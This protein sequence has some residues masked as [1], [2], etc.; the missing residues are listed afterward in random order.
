MMMKHLLFL[1]LTSLFIAAP[2]LA[3][4]ESTCQV[5][6]P[7][8]QVVGNET[9]IEYLMGGVGWTSG[10]ADYLTARIGHQ[11]DPPV[12]FAHT[13]A[14]KYLKT[15]ADEA[16]A[17][18]FDF[19][20]QN[21]YVV[22]CVES[23][24][25]AVPLV[26]MVSAKQEFD[27]ELIKATQI[28]AVL[29]TLKNRT[30]IQ[31]LDD[32][33]GRKVGTNQITN[34]ATH[35][36]YGVL[37][38]HGI[39]HL[40]DPQQVVYF[41][42]SNSA[43]EALLEGKVDVA[44]G[45]TATLDYFMTDDG[46]SARS[47]VKI[48]SPRQTTI[49]TSDGEEKDF[50]FAHTSE[51]VPAYQF[52]AFPHVPT[53][54]QVKIQQEFMDLGDYAA[55]APSLIECREARGCFENN[56]A[57]LEDCFR[58]LPPG[59]IKNCDTTPQL[60]LDAY[61]AMNGRMVTFDKP[62]N[63]FRVRDIQEMTG[64]LNKENPAKPEC[65]RMSNIVDAVTCPPGH[66]ARSSLEIQQECNASGLECFDRDCICN[67]CVKA[68]EVDFFPVYE[69]DKED[70]RTT[71][72][73]SGNG[74][75]KFALCG[76]IHQEHRLSFRAIDNKKRSNATMSGVFLLEDETEEPF[77]FVKVEH[78]DGTYDFNVDLVASRMTAGQKTIKIRIDD[79]EIPES[80]FRIVVLKRDCVADTGDANQ[81]PDDYG[82]CVCKSGTVDLFNKCTPLAILV[83]CIVVPVLVIF[84]LA[85]WLYVRH[86]RAK[87]DSVWKVDPSEIHFDDPP[88]ILG[89]GT[90][91]LVVLAEFRGTRVACKRALPPTKEP[92]GRSSSLLGSTVD[93]G[94]EHRFRSS[95]VL[96]S[97]VDLE[98]GQF[99]SK[100]NGS[101]QF[102]DSNVSL[103]GPGKM[104]KGSGFESTSSATLKSNGV[105][106]RTVKAAKMKDEFVKEMRLL[107]KLRHPSIT[108]V[109]GA[110]LS[111]GT[112]P[113]MIMEYMHFG[114]LYDLLHNECIEL[115]GE[116]LLGMLQDVVSGIR[117][118]HSSDPLILHGDL[119][120][121]NILVDSKF[122]A[123][124]ADFGLSTR[125]SALSKDKVRGTPY[126]MAPELLRRETTNN[127]ETDIYAMGI[128]I[129]EVF[130]RQDPYA[131]EEYDQVL[132]QVADKKT[133]KR[134]HV[135]KNCP[136]EVTNLMKACLREDP[137]HRPT[138]TELD[139]SF[140]TLDAANMKTFD[141][142]SAQK[143]KTDSARTDILLEDIFP[144]HIAQALKEGRKVEPE[145]HEEVTIVFSDIVGYTDMSSSMPATKVSDLLDRLYNAFDSLCE[146]LDIFKVET[147]GDAYMTVTN[148]VKPQP[149]HA[150]LAA[151]F[152]IEAMRVAST[153]PIDVDN[154]SAGFVQLRMGFHSGP[155]VTHVVGTR[156]RRYSLIGDTVNTSS[157]M[158]SNS[159]PGRILCSESTHRLLSKDHS[160]FRV[161][162]RGVIAV[163]GKGEMRTFW[164][165]P[166]DG[167][168]LSER[169]E[170]PLRASKVTFKDHTS[171][172][173]TL[174]DHSSSSIDV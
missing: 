86:H 118:L 57:C 132:R 136:S 88:Q 158:E 93:V 103:A 32:I 167:T 116:V 96:G 47:K 169:P 22:S 114:S 13:S 161:L 4:N 113:M 23:E 79:E 143:R 128:V 43:L 83:P 111:S 97:P 102:R 84:L 172:T 85:V 56:T 94:S 168:E 3:Q 60:A 2:T 99:V 135:P 156:N 8:L 140:R 171:V 33:K 107:S 129:F 121:H 70:N 45:A 146:R 117:F 61:E 159:K 106:G 120:S 151:K 48:L 25:Q 6:K 142:A 38:K 72:S 154:P 139:I 68:F 19:I 34:L 41:K 9:T 173:S 10:L 91:G 75:S 150:S 95:S 20:F 5:P 130:S 155:V 42:N 125:K 115:E 54:V 1:P 174:K 31:T 149:D 80:P 90:F 52:A 65:V 144:P 170:Q 137:S 163:K 7:N 109:M 123:K 11:F 36:C 98:S 64:F 50:P 164:V 162:E 141:E 104:S 30:D 58:E 77:S 21:A 110:V 46:T 92:R 157:R 39:H 160:D 18:G 12:S 108:T 89:R 26:S 166:R 15:P 78:F 53:P 69:D 66:F 133:S 100:S 153:V 24:V 27:G 152:A 35:L 145:T 76:R 55:V 28:G 14:N 29:Y 71:A 134:P 165:E 148:L 131:G 105:F 112:E 119:K 127:K 62:R 87:A 44:C 147:I 37:L 67:P 122:K 49:V 82:E 73:G 74:C 16:P 63:N 124:V 40:Q 101:G 59:S 17:L 51:L 138:A 81:V 126:W